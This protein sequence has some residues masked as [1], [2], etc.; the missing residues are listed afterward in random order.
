MKIEEY[1]KVVEYWKSYILSG[2]LSDYELEVEPGLEQY[3]VAIAL[4]LDTKT[5]RA[6]GETEE[7]Y[8]GYRQAATDILNF[9]GVEL[10]Q[11]DEK[12]IVSVYRSTS[13]ADIQ[14]ELKQNIWG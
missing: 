9:I 4:F 13:P 1:D 3:M 5:V 10:G 14:E 8:D 2:P 11:D 7:Y 12:K 6:S